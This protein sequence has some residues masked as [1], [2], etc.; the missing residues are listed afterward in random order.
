MVQYRGMA[1][2]ARNWADKADL[3]HSPDMS[4]QPL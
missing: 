2:L 3:L 4:L 1:C